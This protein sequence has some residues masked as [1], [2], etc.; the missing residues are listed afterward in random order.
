L[1]K[2]EG[3]EFDRIIGQHHSHTTR[4]VTLG[5]KMAETQRFS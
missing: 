3:D 1:S 2:K 4:S 5:D